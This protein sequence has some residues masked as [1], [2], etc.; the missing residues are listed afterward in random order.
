MVVVVAL[1]FLF[2]F[3]FLLRGSSSSSCN[4]QNTERGVLL[5]NN[6]VPRFESSSS[7]KSCFCGERNVTSQE[8]IKNK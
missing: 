8:H 7:G 3:L 2:L 5:N 4:P 1:M 6:D